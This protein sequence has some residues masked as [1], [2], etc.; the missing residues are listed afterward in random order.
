MDR[1]TDDRDECLRLKKKVLAYEK[2]FLD[3][4]RM[5]LTNSDAVGFRSVTRDK[6][7]AIWLDFEGIK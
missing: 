3:I 6:I 5:S 1:L 7:Q 4:H 2:L